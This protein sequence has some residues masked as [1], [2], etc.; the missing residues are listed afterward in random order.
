MLMALNGSIEDRLLIGVLYGHYTDASCRGDV[1]L[2]LACFTDDGQWNSDIFQCSGK[3]AMR[4]QWNTLWTDWDNVAFWCNI[5]TL[6][7]SGDTAKARSYAREIVALSAGGLFK[8]FGSY[9]DYLVRQNGAW[10]YKR[11]DY[12]PMILEPPE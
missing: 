10:L 4:E 5:A 11:R 1:D 3:Q 7:I 12:L 2:W 8:L 9:D 6:E